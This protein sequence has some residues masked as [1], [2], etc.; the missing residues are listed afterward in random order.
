MSEIILAKTAGYCFGVTRAVKTACDAAEKHGTVYSLGE[1]IHNTDAVDE[2]RKKGVGPVD[3]PAK[4]QG[5]IV[6]RSHGVPRETYDAIAQCGLE[7]VDATCPYVARIH[8]I[9]DEN[10]HDSDVLI[11]GDAAHPEVIGI[12]GFANGEVR[13]ASDA[14]AIEEFAKSDKIFGAKSLIVVV[15]TTFDMCKWTDLQKNIKK[16]YTNLK[17]FDTIC[18]ATYERQREAEE[19]SEQCDAMII[20]GGAH[21]SNT[22]KLADICARHCTALFAENAQ[23]LAA[24]HK[25]VI[26]RLLSSSNDVKIGITAGAS[27]PAYTIKEVHRIMSE[28]IKDEAVDAEFMAALDQM[29][30]VRVYTGQ[31]VKATVVAVNKTEAVVDIGTKHSGYIPAEEL[32]AD[33]SVSPEDAVKVGDVIDCVVTKINDAEGFVYLSKKQVDAQA[34]MEKIVKAKEENATVEGTVTAVV[35]GGVIVTSKDGARVFV[36]A[37]QSG[38]PRNGKLEDI[39]KK[40][41]GFKVIEVNEG[42]GRVV[43]SI[44]AADREA[45]DAVKAKFWDELEVGKKFTGEVKSMESYGVF[46]DLGGVDGMVHLT[47]LTWNRVKHPKEVVNIGDKLEVTVKSYD[48]EK[49]RVSLTAKKPEDNPWTKFLNE[50]AVGDVIKVQIVS[51]TPFGAF[52]QIIPGVDGLIHI[53]QIS[54]ERVTNVAQVL[55]VGQIVDAKITE[56]DEEKSRVS[57]S[58]KALLEEG[59]DDGE[60][61]PA[62]EE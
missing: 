27:T 25:D 42:R 58:I 20:V 48:P 17:I 12:K 30:R 3:D 55:S 57:L 9:V 15:Q 5:C 35:K 24:K 37:S 10:S 33:P 62:E 44:K 45:S 21:S 13:V 16:H 1:L 52:A 46:V 59:S 6:I 49:K 11:I 41:V 54:L 60:E 47:E 50:F 29:E 56:I 26:K 19:L 8:S 31:R 40:E 32:S 18:R 36:P 51:I 38:V 28:I 34:G 23:E 39:L 14:D 22:R 43:G 7:C 61:A 4:A 2:L 53:S